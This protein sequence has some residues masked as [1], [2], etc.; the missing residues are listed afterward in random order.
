[1]VDRNSAR[2]VKRL[3]IVC[4]GRKVA[5]NDIR[6]FCELYKKD[7]RALGYFLM[8]LDGTVEP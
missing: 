4:S 7:T 3:S 8:R 6:R 5:M 2:G 1:M